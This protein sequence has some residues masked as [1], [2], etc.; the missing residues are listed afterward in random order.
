M[1]PERPHKVSSTEGNHTP[2]AYFN[3]LQMVIQKL[4]EA[5]SRGLV[6][7]V[8]GGVALIGTT[9]ELYSPLRENGTVRDLDLL[10]LEDPQQA[11]VTINKEVERERQKGKAIQPIE[12]NR[13][14]AANYN[15][16]FQTLGRF[17]R[18]A[19]GYALVFRK[20]EH[21]L[22]AETMAIKQCQLKSPWGAIS[23][24]TLPP[25]TL[26]HMYLDRVGTLKAKDM[27]KIRDFSRTLS[28]TG[29]VHFA[30][31]HEKYQAFHDFAEAMRAEYPLYTEAVRI[32]NEIDHTMF[33]SLLSGKLIPHRLLKKLIDL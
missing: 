33:D 29:T 2:E 30:E 1:T 15:P 8:V 3:S 10:I 21:E 26:L 20:V 22:P 31:G 4:D 6:Y 14:Q 27:K 16:T 17:K 7:A 23:F 19:N 18:I 28:R 11:V 9:G 13:V 32:F 25:G 24:D 5:K 12:F